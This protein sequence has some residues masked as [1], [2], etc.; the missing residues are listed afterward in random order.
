MC[1]CTQIYNNGNN[2]NDNSDNINI[3][4]SVLLVNHKTR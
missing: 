4:K 3:Y 2:N 1:V